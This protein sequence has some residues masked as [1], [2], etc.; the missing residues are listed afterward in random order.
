MAILRDNWIAIAIVTVAVSVLACAVPQLMQS[1]R[2]F[3]WLVISPVRP[4]GE[5]VSQF[6][7]PIEGL[8]HRESRSERIE[9]A[10]NFFELDPVCGSPDNTSDI[11]ASSD[12]HLNGLEVGRMVHYDINLKGR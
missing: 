4:I 10:N 12:E 7:Q 11:R 8:A 2:Q 1:M 6:R 9:V 3:E 5:A